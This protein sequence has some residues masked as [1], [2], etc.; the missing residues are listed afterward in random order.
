MKAVVTVVCPVLV[1]C[2]L[3]LSAVEAANTKGRKR[4]KFSALAHLPAGAGPAKGREEGTGTLIYAAKIKLLDG[5]SID[6]ESYGNGA[7]RLLGVRK[8]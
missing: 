7:V 1:V 6:I 2:A 3:I 5:N 4:E 8:L